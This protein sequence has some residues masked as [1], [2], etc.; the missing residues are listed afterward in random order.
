MLRDIEIQIWEHEFKKFKALGVR[1]G[2]RRQYDQGND[3]LSR[4]KAQAEGLKEVPEELKANLENTEKLVNQFKGQIDELDLRM[5][6]ALPSEA[7]PEGVVG[8]NQQ[9]EAL[10]QLREYVKAF[11]KHNC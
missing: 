9:L 2:I 10:V 5:N 6:G 7:E 1:E 3:A 8:M 11:V 4:L